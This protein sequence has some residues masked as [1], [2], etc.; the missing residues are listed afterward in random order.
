MIPLFPSTLRM[1]WFKVSAIKGDGCMEICH[2]VAK[3]LAE[4]A[5]VEHAKADQVQ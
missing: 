4:A 5:A 3:F 1:R 2:K